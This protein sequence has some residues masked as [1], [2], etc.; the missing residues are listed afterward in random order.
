MNE[1]KTVGYLYDQVLTLVLSFLCPSIA[2]DEV[3]L[4]SIKVT[5]SFSYLAFNC[6]LIA[7]R[8]PL[9][10]SRMSLNLTINHWNLL[11]LQLLPPHFPLPHSFQKPGILH[12]SVHSFLYTCEPS[13]FS[14]RCFHFNNWTARLHQLTVVKYLLTAREWVYG[15]SPKPHLANF[16]LHS[17]LVLMDPCWLLQESALRQSSMCNLFIRVPLDSHLWK[18]R[19]GNMISWRHNRVI[20]SPK[21]QDT[22][23]K[24]DWLEL[25]RVGL[26]RL[27]SYNNIY[28]LLDVGCCPSKEHALGW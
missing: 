13:W 25:Y 1:N 26:K 20:M 6:L 27:G 12:Q 19:K 23:A 4:Y 18:I 10:F 2:R 11:S 3:S 17:V 5:F 22:G 21:P 8:L 15:P 16:L 14:F 7:V 9:S 28:Q 24:N